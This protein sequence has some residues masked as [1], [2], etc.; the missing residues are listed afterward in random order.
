MSEKVPILVVLGVD[1]D[2]KWHASRFDESD[3]ALATRA[4]E[5][6][7]FHLLRVTVDKTDVY[8][9]AEALPVGK[10]FSSGKAFVPFVTYSS[11]EKLRELAEEGAIFTPPA[12]ETPAPESPTAAMFTDDA[13]DAANELWAKIEVG[14]VVLAAAD[15]EV[16]GPSWWETVVVSI[17]DDDLT[18]RW[19][20]DPTLEPFAVPR[21]DVGLRHPAPM[22]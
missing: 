17:D 7:G 4:A 20:E 10:I 5:L 9:I 3:A 11:F 14:T 8:G 12:N 15:P 19:V 1:S 22:E 16:Y 2:G 18:L 6:M 13:A 21:R